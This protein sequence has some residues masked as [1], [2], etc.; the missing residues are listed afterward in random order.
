MIHCSIQTLIILFLYQSYSS[1]KS[2]FKISFQ[3]INK[4]RPIFFLNLNIRRV[5]FNPKVRK[6]LRLSYNGLKLFKNSFWYEQKDQFLE[7]CDYHNHSLFWEYGTYLVTVW[8]PSRICHS[9][10]NTY[11]FELDIAS[12]T[13]SSYL[14]K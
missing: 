13:V 12:N 4:A 1:I 11:Y 7:Y 3:Q 6:A 9:L 14:Q 5:R 8:I 10:L 2:I